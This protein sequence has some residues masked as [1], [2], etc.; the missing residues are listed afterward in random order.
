MKKFLGNYRGI[1][2]DNSGSKGMCKIY[3][4]GIYPERINDIDI[5]SG[6]YALLLPWAEPAMPLF[7]GSSAGQGICSWPKTGANVWVFFE[8]GDTRRPVYFA[9]IPGG[10]AWIAE[11]NKQYTIQTETTK[12]NIDDKKGIVTLV[13]AEGVNITTPITKIDGN[14]HVTG[15]IEGESEIKD[16]T[17]TMSGDREIYNSHTHTGNLGSVTSPPHIEQ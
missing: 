8:G 17:R 13:V 15:N 6:A 10:T 5:H 7:G 2:L 14:L 1:V 4:P 16:K 11:N 9:G 12:L 3:V